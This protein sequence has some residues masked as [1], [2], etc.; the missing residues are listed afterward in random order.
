[1]DGKTEFAKSLKSY[2]DVLQRKVYEAR[3]NLVENDHPVTA[4]NIK[5]LL[6]GKEICVDK[7][8]LMDIFKHH[9]E[10]MAALVG[11]E[12]APGTLERYTTSYKHTQSFLEWKYQVSDIEE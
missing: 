7:I 3:K 6:L 4:E 2:L 1:M 11:S 5:Y 12:Y 10:Q 8:M 9:N